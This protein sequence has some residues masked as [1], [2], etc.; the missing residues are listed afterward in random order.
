MWDP[1]IIG[2]DSNSSSC[3]DIYPG[4]YHYSIVAVQVSALSDRSILFKL[5][6]PHSQ[7][8]PLYKNCEEGC[9]CVSVWTVSVYQAQGPGFD[10]QNFSNQM[11]CY[12]HI[13]SAALRRW[14][15]ET[16]HL[17][18][19]VQFRLPETL[20]RRTKHKATTTEIIIINC[21][22]HQNATNYRSSKIQWTIFLRRLAWATPFIKVSLMKLCRKNK[23]RQTSIVPPRVWLAVRM[24][25][26]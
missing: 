1:G 5:S 15:Q 8:M 18:S 10:Q 25:E 7:W 2:E 24:N 3:G 20:P 12:T 16:P 21:E 6:I 17:Q 14:R 23:G 11:C 13:I 19:W 22:G 4:K 9:G 26:W